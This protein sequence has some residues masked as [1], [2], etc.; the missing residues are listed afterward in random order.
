[1][2]GKMTKKDHEEL[3]RILDRLEGSIKFDG[4]AC[5]LIRSLRERDLKAQ[6]AF[7]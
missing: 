6:R 2:T 3:D 7:Q 5:D 4:T 1:M